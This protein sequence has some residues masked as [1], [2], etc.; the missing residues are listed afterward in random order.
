MAADMLS[1]DYLTTMQAILRSLAIRIQAGESI[2]PEDWTVLDGFKENLGNRL[3]WENAQTHVSHTFRL[4]EQ[5]VRTMISMRRKWTKDDFVTAVDNMAGVISTELDLRNRSGV[6]SHGKLTATVRQILQ[7]LFENLTSLTA[8]IEHRSE[9]RDFAWN[10]NMANEVRSCLAEINSAI[11]PIKRAEKDDVEAVI[12]Y[13]LN[14]LSMLENY[15]LHGTQ[16]EL[17]RR[18][19]PFSSG[20]KGLLV[21]SLNKVSESLGNLKKLVY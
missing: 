18:R 10:E 5:S 14:I 21:P 2:K 7:G 13:S 15:R 3:E 6:T 19:Y 20:V 4:C 1:N 16:V 12:R 9:A 8:D 11:S 17:N